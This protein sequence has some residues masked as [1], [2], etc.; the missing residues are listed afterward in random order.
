MPDCTT[1]FVQ[2]QWLSEG[3]VCLVGLAKRPGKCITRSHLQPGF[4]TRLQP[5]EVELIKI[6]PKSVCK[7]CEPLQTIFPIDHPGLNFEVI[8]KAET[9]TVLGGLGFDREYFTWS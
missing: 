5:S 6:G 3:S 8:M 1:D 2:K 9:K 4:Q 7:V